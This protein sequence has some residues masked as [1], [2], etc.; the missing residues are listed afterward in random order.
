VCTDDSPATIAAALGR[1][2][3]RGGRVASRQTVVPLDE[4]LLAR[5]MIRVY[6]G[7]LRRA[8]G[9]G[10]SRHGHEAA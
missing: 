9:N 5:K 10:R 8:S 2:L 1:V 6:R 3:A 4:S 7:A